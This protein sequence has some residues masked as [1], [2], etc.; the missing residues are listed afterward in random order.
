VRGEAEAGPPEPLRFA[1]ADYGDLYSYP[2]GLQGV[3][4]EI[5]REAK[6]ADRKGKPHKP[7]SV[8]VKQ[9]EELGQI[10][11]LYL[12]GQRLNASVL[13]K[14]ERDSIEALAGAAD[15]LLSAVRVLCKP[16]SRR[17]MQLLAEWLEDRQITDHDVDQAVKFVDSLARL[18]PDASF[19]SRSALP[20]TDEV[21]LRATWDGIFTSHL[22]RGGLQL[23]L[24]KWWKS[25]TGLSVDV[26]ADE[27][28]P[29]GVFL[30]KL[31]IRMQVPN[32][33]GFSATAL[34]N[35]RKEGRR[36]TKSRQSPQELLEALLRSRDEARVANA[37]AQSDAL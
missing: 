32:R 19:Q 11:A 2:N 14:P 5:I 18:R 10:V 23:R 6:S 26:A 37:A 21:R 29:Y 34:K 16:D 8:T 33:P 27:E 30:S 36:E 12:D 24:D 35:A 22:G 17:A 15:K 9:W 20:N 25:T 28:T 7:F 13:R 3:L 31:L 4:E 1:L